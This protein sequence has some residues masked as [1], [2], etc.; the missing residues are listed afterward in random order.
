M[1]VAIIGVTVVVVVAVAFLLEEW[2]HHAIVRGVARHVPARCRFPTLRGC[3]RDGCQHR[4]DA[5]DCTHPEAGGS[6]G[7]R[8]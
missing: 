6:G 1:I 2:Y 7:G 4:N 8:R 3:I 5:G